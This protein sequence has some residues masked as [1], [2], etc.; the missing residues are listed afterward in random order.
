MI[1][2]PFIAVTGRL[3]VFL[4]PDAS[5]ALYWISVAGL[6]GA[7]GLLVVRGML[8][9]IL[10]T[11]AIVGYL[12]FAL[13]RFSEFAGSAVNLNAL[14]QFSGLLSVVA[15]YPLVRTTEGLQRV[16]TA[17]LWCAL[18]Y[19]VIY[20]AISLALVAGLI[21]VDPTRVSI[22]LQ[23]TLRRDRV[24]LASGVAAF[25][26]AMSLARLVARPRPASFAML[27]LFATAL[28]LSQSRVFLAVV[29]VLLAL[30]ALTRRPSL[31]SVLA[32]TLFAVVSGY[33][34]LQLGDPQANPFVAFGTDRSAYIRSLS[35]E[36]ARDVVRDNWL[37]GVGQANAPADLIQAM[38]TKT[39]SPN[40][41]GIVGVLYGYG[42]IGVLLFIGA[43]ALCC[44]LPELDLPRSEADGLALTGAALAAY[45]IIAPTIW[46]GSGSLFFGLILALWLATAAGRAR[47]PRPIRTGHTALAR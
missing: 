36:L 26:A 17:L 46:Y 37:L 3:H 25:G 29:V 13:W 9:P 40:D 7:L 8:A 5:T 34:L 22:V 16:V 4:G 45:G 12:I 38:S 31:V 41:L 18:I 24:A 42:V 19:V 35:F 27:A 14:A 20:I 21:A 30:Y 15:F 1:A 32:F 10:A 39:F 11:V 2:A 44:R 6:L 28:G 47:A 33:M 43:T 23:D